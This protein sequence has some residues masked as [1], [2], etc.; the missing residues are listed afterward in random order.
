[1][2][3]V[4]GVIKTTEAHLTKKYI[5]IFIALAVVFTFMTLA[6]SEARAAFKVAVVRSETLNVR[7]GPGTSSSKIG[8]VNRG[9]KLFVIK[10][11]GSWRQVILT[12]GK[13]GWVY[14]PYLAVLS[15]GPG[16]PA[17]PDPRPKQ[18]PAQPKPSGPEQWPS[19]PGKGQTA[20]VIA[21]NVN[22]RSGPGTSYQILAVAA[23]AERVTV[24][25]LSN[26]WYSVQLSDGTRGWISARYVDTRTDVSRGGAQTP[27]PSSG[28]QPGSGQLQDPATPAEPQPASKLVKMEVV[29][30]DTG[31]EA[32]VIT[33]EKALSYTVNRLKNPE[34]LV[35]DINNTDKGDIGDLSPGNSDFISQVRTAQFSLTPMTVRLVLDLKKIPAYKAG[36]SADGLALTLS[37]TEPTIKGKTIVLD[38]GHGGYDPG[39]VGVTG[40][41]EKEVNLDIALRVQK[42]LTD[43]GAN[44]VMTRSDDTFLALSQRAAVANNAYADVFVSIHANS[45]TNASIGGTSV[46]YYAPS[47]NPALYSQ[48]ARRSSLA[49]RVQGQLVRN[50]GIRDIGTLTAN[51]AVLRETLMPSILVETAFLSNKAEEALLKDDAFR[52]KAAQAIAQGLAEY[53][54]NP[55]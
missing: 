23:K 9:D 27:S 18:P 28:E 49:S 21:E 54:A 33:G 42:L 35:I 55:E 38:P 43:M 4:Q 5:R 17:K 34:R 16:L 37:L 19:D 31:G 39:A 51:F 50:L 8:T 7:S 29:R 20:L 40:L 53:F 44:V 22:V 6:A 12:G 45:N 14:K 47:S 41:K 46:Y 10:E 15:K 36:L 13:L 26:G 32:L 52:D 24:F 30:V 3:S 2:F 1:V 25:T 11:S 48:L